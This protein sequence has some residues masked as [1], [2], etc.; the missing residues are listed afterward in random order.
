MSARA[1]GARR[2]TLKDG[3]GLRPEVTPDHRPT[4][5]ELVAAEPRLADLLAEARAV[6]SRG[7]PHFCA[8][9][10]WYGYAGHP[11]IKPRL[12]R[13]VGWHAQ[14]EDP[15]LWSSQAYD[16]AYQ[17]IYRALPDCRACACL[18]AWT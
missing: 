17:T 7:K 2:L 18:R 1:E 12:L 5:E 10:V 15:I 16:V 8:N 3:Q 13:L 4:W 11:G 14:G 9:A 6:S